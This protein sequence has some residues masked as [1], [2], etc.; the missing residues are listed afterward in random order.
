MR[1]SP[2]FGCL[3]SGRAVGVRYPR[4]VGAGVRAWGPC[5]GPVARVPC[6]G[7]R[8]TGPVGDVW[9]QAPLLPCFPPSGRAAG[10]R[11]P[12]AV[13]AGVGVCGVC[14]V[15]AVRVVMRGVAFC[16]SLWCSPLRCSCAVL[17]STSACR[18]PFPACVP[19]SAAGYPLFFSWLRRSLPFPLIPPGAPFSLACTF[20][21]PPLWCVS[22]SCSL[23]ARLSPSLGPVRQRKDGGIRAYGGLVRSSCNVGTMFVAAACSVA[24]RIT[25]LSSHLCLRVCARSPPFGPYYGVLMSLPVPIPFRV[26]LVV[27]PLYSLCK[28]ACQGG[29]PP[30]YSPC[31]LIRPTPLLVS[32]VGAGRVSVVR[33]ILAIA[34]RLGMCPHLFRLFLS[35]VAP[36]VCAAWHVTYLPDSLLTR[37]FSC[38]ACLGA[39]VLPIQVS[40]WEWGLFLLLSSLGRSRFRP[41]LARALAAPPCPCVHLCAHFSAVAWFTSYLRP[42]WFHIPHWVPFFVVLL[43][44]AAWHVTYLRD[45]L[46]TRILSCVACLGAVVLPIQVSV[47]GRGFCLA[48]SSL[49]QS[50]FTP[51]LSCTCVHV[52]ALF[53]TLAW[54]ISY[55]HRAWLHT[56]SWLPL[57][58]ALPACEAW[59][60]TYL[61]GCNI[62]TS[63]T[64]FR[65]LCLAAPLYSLCGS[66]LTY[67]SS[68]FVCHGTVVLPMQVGV[69]GRRFCILH[70]WS[71]TCGM[72][73][74]CTCLCAFPYRGTVCNILALSLLHLTVLCLLRRYLALRGT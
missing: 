42:A 58:V 53:S 27:A 23:P 11:W 44:C 25:Y 9:V 17:C 14:G 64:S 54:F 26:L 24:W 49:G 40:V 19:C 46:L 73:H 12:R 39:V 18:A 45:S 5:T 41:L 57:L 38:D 29:G 43:A 47:R 63:P 34:P 10:A 2:S 35:F 8:A 71:H 31:S 56:P 52:C 1:R 6:G 20:S 62:L 36:L 32:V 65:V 7:L 61:R 33:N 69:R 67:I 16:L 55:L 37:I 50:W 68:C 4:A 72:S 66:I 13:G 21:L 51:L 30:S 48:R 22:L 74:T 59:H 3:P 70:A 28:R 60:V 15:R